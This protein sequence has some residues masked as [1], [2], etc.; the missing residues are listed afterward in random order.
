MKL[1]S[2]LWSISL[3]RKCTV[4]DSLRVEPFKLPV[5]IVF[6]VIPEVLVL[7][8]V[9]IG[10][11]GCK[12]TA[13]GGHKD[14]SNAHDDEERLKGSMVLQRFKGKTLY[15]RRAVVGLKNTMRSYPLVYESNTYRSAT[16]PKEIGVVCG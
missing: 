7:R 2:V 12:P 5:I 4:V 15:G 16:S 13:V 11:F 3:I 9:H 14:N 8:P 6:H 10:S 1:I